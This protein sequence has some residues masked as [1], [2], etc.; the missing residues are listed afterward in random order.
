[1][2]PENGAGR[3]R[4]R[5]R[6]RRAKAAQARDPH[7]SATSSGSRSGAP[8]DGRELAGRGST[9]SAPWRS[10]SAGR[11]RRHPATKWS[12]STKRCPPPM[13]RPRFR[14]AICVQSAPSPRCASAMRHRTSPAWTVWTAATSAGAGAVEW[15][16]GANG[17][18]AA[19]TTEG[20][21]VV[22]APA[23]DASTSGVPAVVSA[24]TPTAMR[25]AIRSSGVTM[26]S[27]RT[28]PR[29]TCTAT[30]C[31]SCEVQ[32]AHA[33]H[34]ASA[35]AT[36]ASRGAGC[37]ECPSPPESG[38]PTTS[39]RTAGTAVNARTAATSAP[40][41]SAARWDRR[42]PS[43]R[44]GRGRRVRALAT[45]RPDRDRVRER[46]RLRCRLAY[47]GQAAPAGVGQRG[48]HGRGPP[49]VLRAA[50]TAD[51]HGQV[52]GP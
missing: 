35:S 11:R 42:D 7:P 45:R 21:T 43:W 13:S 52:C 26:P 14:A 33:I 27:G 51:L 15:S 2:S 39:T 36:S 34:A 4:C 9:R 37:H 40:T 24:S 17:R 8:P 49:D 19:A 20:A 12:G 3:C 48:G 31:T 28:S 47:R 6:A 29:R 44:P 25:A 32:T 38:L 5:R 46:S 10:A 18:A 1:M 30:P 41:T 50:G 23:P 22:L 16:A